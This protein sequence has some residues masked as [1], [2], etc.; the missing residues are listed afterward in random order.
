MQAAL[1]SQP[2]PRHQQPS[3]YKPLL[4]RYRC[5]ASKHDSRYCRHDGCSTSHR[6]AIRKVVRHPNDER[7]TLH[8]SQGQAI[9]PACDTEPLWH[10][11]ALSLPLRHD[12]HSAGPRGEGYHVRPKIRP[13][14]N[15]KHPC[16]VAQ[17][18]ILSNRCSHIPAGHLFDGNEARLRLPPLASGG[19]RKQHRIS[20]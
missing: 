13:H 1:S 8:R 18:M 4:L 2:L 19:R 20:E 14:G 3:Q 17:T 16:P 10:R 11:Q 6:F 15:I 9:R 5:L 7:H 12:E